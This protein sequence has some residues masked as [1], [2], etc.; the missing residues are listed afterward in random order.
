LIDVYFP[1]DKV[2]KKIEYRLLV[3][4]IGSKPPLSFIH[5][6]TPVTTL[7]ITKTMFTNETE[8]EMIV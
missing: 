5:L 8:V 2:I 1:A 6:F 4:K 3:V 7:V